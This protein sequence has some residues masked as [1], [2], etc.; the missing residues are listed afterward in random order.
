MGGA[1]TVKGLAPVATPQHHRSVAPHDVALAG[2]CATSWL[3]WAALGARRSPEGALRTAARGLLGGAGAFGMALASYDLLKVCGAEVR[4]EEVAAGGGGAII[5]AGTIGL[6][7][8]TAKLA[9]ILLALPRR[10]RPGGAM[11][12]TVVVAA[13]FAVLEAALTLRGAAPALAAARAFLAPVAHAILAAPLGFATAA[14]ARRRAGWFWLAPALVA[15][16]GLHA[17][18][19]LSLADPRMGSA[20]YAAVL[21]APALAVFLGARRW[22]AT[23]GA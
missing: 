10:F 9:G 7:E 8:E 18:G 6:V 13:A 2:V 3:A 23:E 15:S 5:A 14:G 1:H 22:R 11:R 4:W 21:L 16:A 12:I 19:D 17:L 20:G